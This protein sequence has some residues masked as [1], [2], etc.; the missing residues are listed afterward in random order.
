MRSLPVSASHTR[1][2]GG[3]PQFWNHLVRAF[4]GACEGTGG[5]VVAGWGIVK[6]SEAALVASATA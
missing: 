4:V 1:V 5:G 2:G 3:D 6:L